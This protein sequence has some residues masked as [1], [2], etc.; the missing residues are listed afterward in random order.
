MATRFVDRGLLLDETLVVADLHLGRS[1]ASNVQASL[2]GDRATL[3]HVIALVDRHDPERVVIAGDVLESFSSVPDGVTDHLED[4]EQ[5]IADRDIAL[6][7]IAGN[8]DP[9]LTEVWDYPLADRVRIDETLVVHG[10]TDPD[11]PSGVDRIVMGHEHPAIEIEGHKRFCFLVGEALYRG[12]DVIVVPAINRLLRGT[13]V[14]EMR[15]RDFHSPIL[16]AADPLRPVVYDVESEE[17][18]RFPT[19][20]QFREML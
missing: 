5:S 17:T 6:D 9:M 2:G 1:A 7:V 19:L 16:T 11:L 10:D 3:D 13:T 12:R 20:G 14:N 15:G 4:F 18:L 8:H